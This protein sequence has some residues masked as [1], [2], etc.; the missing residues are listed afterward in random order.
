MLTA[1]QWHEATALS[2]KFTAAVGNGWPSSYDITLHFLVHALPIGN[3]QPRCHQNATRSVRTDHIG[4]H[5]LYC[6]MLQSTE[7]LSGLLSTLCAVVMP[8]RQAL[9]VNIPLNFLREVSS[10][11]RRK[12]LRKPLLIVDF[13]LQVKKDIRYIKFI[14]WLSRKTERKNVYWE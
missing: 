1:W 9:S 11:C 13:T 8:A 14:A 6:T 5:S 3:G 12:K 2:L 7:R 10:F 4:W